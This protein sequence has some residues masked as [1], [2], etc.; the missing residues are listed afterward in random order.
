MPVYCK[1]RL[2]V[3]VLVAQLHLTLCYHVDCSLP[4]SSV[5]GIFQLK[6]LK[7]VAIPYSRRYSWPGIE[8]RSSPLQADS[9]LSE[10]PRKPKYRFLNIKNC[11]S[12]Y[13]INFWILKLTSEWYGVKLNF[14]KCWFVVMYFLRIN[15][16]S[17]TIVLCLVA[18][19]CLTLCNPMDC[20][21]LAPLSMGILQA[22]I[23]EWVAMPSSKESSQPR[24]W[25]QVSCITGG[26]FTDWATRGALPTTIM[27]IILDISGPMEAFQSCIEYF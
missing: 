5:H 8:P 9:S 6:I 26:F 21:P 7:W 14:L 17:A 4:G 12:Y 20:S 24:G 11:Q 23:L 3:K 18:Q 19:S 15:L 25:T 1:Q 22:R 2:K 27:G 13:K 10:P 16:S